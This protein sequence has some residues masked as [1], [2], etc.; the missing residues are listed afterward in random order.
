MGTFLNHPVG[1]FGAALATLWVRVLLFVVAC[2]TGTALASLIRPDD[3]LPVLMPLA[4]AAIAWLVSPLFLAA[5][6]LTVVLLIALLRTESLAVVIG[7]L[8]GTWL[9][10]F[11]LGMLLWLLW[12]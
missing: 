2:C 7:S 5:D 11:G 4:Y 3:D 1:V 12:G 6:V 8:T 9:V 10:W